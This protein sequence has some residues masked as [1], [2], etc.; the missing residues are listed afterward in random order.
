MAMVLL[1]LLKKKKIHHR[2]A[3]DHRKYIILL[4]RR[5]SY[6]AFVSTAENTSEVILLQWH[7]IA[8]NSAFCEINASAV[9]GI[10]NIPYNVVSDN[11]H[12]VIE[13]GYVK[14]HCGIKLA[15]VITGS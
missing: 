3:D 13:A 8:L 12:V 15:S 1:V 2:T 10:Y 7:F 5:T 6:V 4:L 9:C 14:F 11:N